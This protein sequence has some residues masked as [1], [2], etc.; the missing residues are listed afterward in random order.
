MCG[1][2]APDSLFTAQEEAAYDGDV[3]LVQH[4]GWGNGITGAGIGWNGF[5]VFAQPANPATQPREGLLIEVNETIALIE[6]AAFSG[7]SGSGVLVLDAPPPG[8]TQPGAP[9]ALGQLTHITVGGLGFVQR[10]DFA[11]ERA[12]AEMGKTFTLA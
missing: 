5:G 8:S 11:L 3:E 1:W 4:F 9:Q 12:G 6:T 2:G 10:L 7:D